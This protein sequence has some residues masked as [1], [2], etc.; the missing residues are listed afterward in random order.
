ME[1]TQF[2]LSTDIHLAVFEEMESM[3]YVIIGS[4]QWQKVLG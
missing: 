3:H 2:L 1:N 4:E